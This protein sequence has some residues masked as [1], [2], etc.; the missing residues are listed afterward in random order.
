MLHGAPAHPT[1]LCRNW[2]ACAAH[3]HHGRLNTVSTHLLGLL[4]V[5]L[6]HQE[7][8]W[9]LRCPRLSRMGL[10]LEYFS[11]SAVYERSAGLQESTHGSKLITRTIWVAA[12]SLKGPQLVLKGVSPRKVE[13]VHEIRVVLAVHR[14]RPRG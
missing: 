4:L 1:R 7:E 6:H 12:Y 8:S 9:P 13:G 2:S 3:P 5:P 11:S 10:T 14:R